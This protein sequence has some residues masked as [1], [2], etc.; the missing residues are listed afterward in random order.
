MCLPAF[1]FISLP[2]LTRTEPLILCVINLTIYIRDREASLVVTNLERIFN[3]ITGQMQGHR[4]LYT[5]SAV[6]QIPEPSST[7][8]PAFGWLYQ[9]FGQKMVLC[10]GYDLNVF[11]RACVLGAQS[12]GNNVKTKWDP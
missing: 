10:V 5:N 4:P 11:P 12:Q 1:L 7:L 3:Q 8:L 9:Y 6:Y 2:S